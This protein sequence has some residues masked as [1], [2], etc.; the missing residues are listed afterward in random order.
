MYVCQQCLQALQMKPAHGPIYYICVSIELENFAQGFC[1][2]SNLLIDEDETEHGP[3]EAPLVG[4]L[5]KQHDLKQCGQQRRQQL[6]PLLQVL[7]HFLHTWH[8]QP[9]NT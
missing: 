1:T 9:V 6:R 3:A 4:A 5:L 2:Q 8:R 7:R